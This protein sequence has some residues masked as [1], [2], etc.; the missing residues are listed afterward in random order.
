MIFMGT[1]LFE[2]ITLYSI[3]ARLLVVGKEI[4]EHYFNRT[5]LS[6]IKD[7]YFD[8]FM[9]EFPICDVAQGKIWDTLI[10]SKGNPSV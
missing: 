7:S 10:L 5:E 2:I 4:I 1:F 6:L 3:K 9:S 8:A